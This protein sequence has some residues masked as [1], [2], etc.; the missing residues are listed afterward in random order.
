MGIVIKKHRKILAAEVACLQH[1]MNQNLQYGTT[2]FSNGNF[3]LNISSTSIS[4]QQET[5]KT[6][7]GSEDHTKRVSLRTKIIHSITRT[8]QGNALTK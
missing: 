5:V 2:A 3:K 7:T 8:T 1:R 4:K 6:P